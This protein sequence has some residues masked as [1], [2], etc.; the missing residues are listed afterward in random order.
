[1]TEVALLVAQ[2]SVADS[3]RLIALGTTDSDTVGT[4]A[5]TL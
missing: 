3:P 1:V 5:I 4:V 2:E